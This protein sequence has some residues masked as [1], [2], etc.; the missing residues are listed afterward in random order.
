MNK[1]N[2]K[3]VEN[4]FA[5]RSVILNDLWQIAILSVDN[6]EFY[7]IPWGWIDEWENESDALVREV[8][9]EAGCIIDIISKLWTSSYIDPLKN[10]KNDI[11]T[12]YISKKT[13]DYGSLDL[14]YFEKSRNF[15]LLWVTFDE[16]INLF[17]SKVTKNPYWIKQ[18]DRDLAF[19]LKAKEYVDKN[20]FAKN[21]I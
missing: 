17:N 3:W 2:E 6:W 11:S 13:G 15:K 1:L 20:G 16:A 10:T 12:C 9:E 8:K 5:V 21:E 14:T 4:R 7:K 19:V 18:N